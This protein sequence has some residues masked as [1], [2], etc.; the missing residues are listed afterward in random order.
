[1]IYY[2]DLV[3]YGIVGLFYFS[4]WWMDSHVKVFG[5]QL[6][7]GLHSAWVMDSQLSVFGY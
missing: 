5:A 7:A 4:A 6:V 2:V 3:S 1:M